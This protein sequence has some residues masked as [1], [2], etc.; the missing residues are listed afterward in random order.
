M[1]NGKE[2]W[3]RFED[4]LTNHDISTKKI[5]QK[6][7][8]SYTQFQDN[9]CK[10][11]RPKER[12]VILIFLSV[13]RKDSIKELL[14]DSIMES[15]TIDRKDGKKNLTVAILKYNA[16]LVTNSSNEELKDAKT[17]YSAIK[18]NLDEGYRIV[19]NKKRTEWQ[20]WVLVSKIVQDTIQNAV[21]KHMKILMP[22]M[23]GTLF[24]W[25]VLIITLLYLLIQ[26]CQ[27]VLSNIN[28]GIVFFFNILCVIIYAYRK[29]A[30]EEIEKEVTYYKKSDCPII[31]F[32]ETG[33]S[34]M[35]MRSY[36]ENYINGD[37]VTRPVFYIRSGCVKKEMKN[38]NEYIF[39]K[40]CSIWGWICLCKL[41][42]DIAGNPWGERNLIDEIETL[43]SNKKT[44][45]VIQRKVVDQKNAWKEEFLRDLNGKEEIKEQISQLS[46]LHWNFC[47]IDGKCDE[48]ILFPI[49]NSV[50]VI[51]K[52]GPELRNRIEQ[53]IRNTQLIC[54]TIEI[55]IWFIEVNET[56]EKE[57]AIQVQTENQSVKEK[58]NILWNDL[59]Q[60]I[61]DRIIQF[62][63]SVFVSL[64]GWKQL[65]YIRR[66]IKRLHRVNEISKQSS[67]KREQILQA[68]F[69][70][71]KED[72]ELTM[73]MLNSESKE[74]IQK[75]KLVREK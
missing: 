4:G 18:N 32:N 20:K 22:L 43:A 14:Y 40:G 3:F 63:K 46:E 50:Y 21:D 64:A 67:N 11:K 7:I 31:F 41:V 57:I 68:I 44:S 51:Y 53:Q 37:K 45:L 55:Q 56:E 70:L 26:F 27:G 69:E 2:K 16:A 66:E 54:A 35:W 1:G 5:I 12:R 10:D 61:F 13:K 65:F 58:W 48:S 15:Y 24:K 34:K 25:C 60:S 30:M 6:N 19:D 52:R 36:I 8:N 39:P 73:V 72:P 33:K 47:W 23:R 71:V 42:R 75:R 28:I 38:V 29:N 9:C 17:E 74:N 49:G 62:E 59:W